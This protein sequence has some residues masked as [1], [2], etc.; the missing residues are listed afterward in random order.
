MFDLY[1][2]LG[3]VAVS[4]CIVALVYWLAKRLG[5]AEARKRERESNLQTS[6]KLVELLARR[7]RN[8]R[9]L[10]DW[11]RERAEAD[12]PTMPPRKRRGRR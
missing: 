8:R 9:E 5:A 1:V 12:R 4:L 2:V 3:G 7:D 10:T 11:M 6:R